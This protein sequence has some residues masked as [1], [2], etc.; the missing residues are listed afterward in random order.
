MA[1]VWPAFLA[2]TIPV[3]TSAKPVCMKN[4]RNPANKRPVMLVTFVIDN[5]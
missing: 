3:S 4:T 2:R 1:M 5:Q